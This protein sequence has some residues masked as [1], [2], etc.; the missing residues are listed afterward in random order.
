M[1]AILRVKEALEPVKARFALPLGITIEKQTQIKILS[2][3][4]IFLFTTPDAS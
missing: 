4:L 2:F 3:K 1:K